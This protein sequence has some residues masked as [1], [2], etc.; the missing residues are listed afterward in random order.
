[1]L[2]WIGYVAAEQLHNSVLDSRYKCAE[3]DRL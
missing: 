1:M 2:K 3:M